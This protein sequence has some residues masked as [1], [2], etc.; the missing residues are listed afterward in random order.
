M[1]TLNFVVGDDTCGSDPLVEV[2]CVVIH[3]VMPSSVY[4]FR[5]SGYDGLKGG[6]GRPIG[7]FSI[8]YDMGTT[9]PLLFGL[10]LLHVECTIPD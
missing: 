5:V 2:S 9:L 8:A 7:T 4:Y 1:A 3:N 10:L 6:Y